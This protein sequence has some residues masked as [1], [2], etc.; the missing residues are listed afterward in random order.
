MAFAIASGVPP[1]RGLFTAIIAGFLISALGGS[2]VQIG[3]PTGA[4]VV[5]IYDIIARN[6]YEGLAIC[7]LLAAVF[8]VAMG[9]CRAGSCIKY[10]PHPLI[11]GFTTGIATII[12][13]CQIKDFLG[14]SLEKVP[15]SFVGKWTAY[16]KAFPSIDPWT[17]GLGAGTLGVILIIRRFFPRI[18][19]GIAA[20]VLATS[21]CSLAHLPVDTIASRFGDLPR[22]L[23]VP[24]LPVFSIPDGKWIEYLLD[25]LAIACLGG[26][27]SLLSAAIADGMMGTK[28]KSNCELV[29]QGLAN[30]ASVIF[31][32]IPA[33]GAIARTAANVKT[34]A[35]T[36]IAGMIHALALF[37]IILAL[38]PIAS[39]IPLAGLAAILIMVAWNMSEIEHFIQL[40]KAPFSDCGILLTAFFLTVFVD[41]TVA[42]IFGMGLSSFLFMRRMSQSSRAVPVPPLVSSLPKPHIVEIFEMTGPLFF[43]ATDML[44]DLT[45]ATPAPKALILKMNRVSMVDASG[46]KALKEFFHRCRKHGTRLILSDL[47]EPAKKD[48]RHFHFDEHLGPANIFSDFEQALLSAER[49]D[50]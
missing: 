4:F 8:L 24:S 1:E 37:F 48:L 14:L 11:T 16:I 38:A 36:P 2:R 49:V 19:W 20:I 32:G 42:I 39:Q 46:A 50:N 3:G 22:M 41:I 10:V 47:S 23:P 33:T 25:A 40:L 6:G 35:V 34:G 7:T 26:I 12:F 45:L 13:S 5:I 44:R 9:L 21:V 43:G 28:H 31:G 18:P 30:F 17:A 27:E 29:G 15:A